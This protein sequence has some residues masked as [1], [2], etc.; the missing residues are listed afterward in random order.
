[1]DSE[2]YKISQE[3]FETILNYFDYTYN[4]LKYYSSNITKFQDITNQYCLQIKELFKLNKKKVSNSGEKYIEINLDINLKKDINNKIKMTPGES[5]KKKINISPIKNCIDNLNCFLNEYIDYIGIF[6]N[7]LN[8]HLNQLNKYFDLTNNEVNCIKTSHESQK[9]NYNIKYNEFIELNKKL[10]LLYYKAEK[11][12]VE[13][14][15]DKKLNFNKSHLTESELNLYITQERLNQNAIIEKYN[16]LDNFGKIFYD[17]TKEKINGVKDFTS[18]LF[19]KFEDFLKIFFNFYNKSFMQ[20]MSNFLKDKEE[21]NIGDEVKE[22]LNFDKLLDSSVKIVDE[23]KIKSVFDEY[24][25]NILKADKERVEINSDNQLRKALSFVVMNNNTRC[26]YILDEE[27][28]YCI[29]KKMYDNFKLINTNNYNLK[30]GEKQLELKTIID[31]L[32]YIPEMKTPLSD[33]EEKDSNDLTKKVDKNKKNIINEN[34]NVNNNIKSENN[35]IKDEE[36]EGQ[37]K[38][39]EITKEEVEYLC[40][41]MKEKIYQEYFLIKINNFRSSGLF[42]LP[43]VNFN[44]LIDIFS[45]ICK[46]F[47]SKKLN[48]NNNEI[49]IVDYKIANLVI[50]LSQTFYTIIDNKKTYIQNQLK[51]EDIFHKEEFWNQMM[52]YSVENERANR[53]LITNDVLLQQRVN[54]NYDKIIFA[55]IIPY[56][57]AMNGFGCSKDEIKKLILPII[58]KYKIPEANKQ[59]LLE[60][61]EKKDK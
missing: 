21:K 23:N 39:K 37:N 60:I 56:V 47:Y 30:V 50:I 18:S 49:I 35:K 42:K 44:Y 25:I 54:D 57:E 22:K 59:I 31:K 32:T 4:K 43:I 33:K 9:Q 20:P 1:M 27:D 55:Q 41:C 11:K 24:N 8:V 5:F 28:I 6:T 36:K 26:K 38:D 10:K 7:S 15:T 53:A 45:E 51:K 2:L 58:D 17:S 46:N 34:N 52:I 29:V 14:Y 61:I 3:N 40:K 12:I 48:E 19:Q 13:Y 16:L